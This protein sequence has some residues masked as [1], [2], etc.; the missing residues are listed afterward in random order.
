MS[1]IIDFSGISVSNIIAQKTGCDEDLIRHSILNSIR[2]YNK[3]FRVEYGEVIIACDSRSWRK[4]IFPQYKF[5]R[6]KKRDKDT[7]LDW[8]GIYKIIDK[9]KL[10]LSEHFPYRVI[11]VPRCEADDIIGV[12]AQNSQE[13]GLHEKIMVVSADKDFIQLQKFD[14]IKQYS[15]LTKKFIVN[16]DP[17]QYLFEH[18]MKGDSSDGVPNVL[19]SDDTFVEKIRQSPM[20]K[21]KMALYGSVGID[22]ISDIMDKEIYRNFIRNRRMIDL[23]YVPE[24]LKD[25]IGQAYRVSENKKGNDSGRILNYL[26]KNRCKML[27][28]CLDEFL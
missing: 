26:V 24:D 14:N 28:E 8:S 27:I 21:K 1:I 15:P 13:F 16:D 3:K 4:E 6:Q 5:S 9:I 12:L 10:E 25:K 23:E 20:T 11:Q 19:S 18:I 7:V 2:M 17:V 22:N